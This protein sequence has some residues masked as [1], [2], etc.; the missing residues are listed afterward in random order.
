MDFN[1]SNRRKLTVDLSFFLLCILW[2]FAM[3]SS[4]WQLY[5]YIHS[6]AILL[7]W[8]CAPIVQIYS[9]YHLA[10]PILKCLFLVK[11]QRAANL[12]QSLILRLWEYL[13]LRLKYHLV[14]LGKCKYSINV[15]YL[16]FPTKYENALGNAKVTW[17][18]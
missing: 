8:M 3:I 2:S 10:F 9:S 18:A 17:I 15:Y 16:E 11:L 7:A 14:G 12:R 4:P 13:I 5:I 1:V 6:H